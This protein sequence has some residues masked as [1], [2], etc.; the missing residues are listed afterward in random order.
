MERWERAAAERRRRLQEVLAA[1]PVNGRRTAELRAWQK[2]LGAK[3]AWL[4]ARLDHIIEVEKLLESAL[5]G[6]Q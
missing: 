3:K 2:N 6:S 4:Q 1:N 5:K